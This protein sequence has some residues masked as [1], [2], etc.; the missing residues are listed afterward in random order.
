MKSKLFAI[1]TCALLLMIA[2]CEKPDPYV[3]PGSTEDPHWKVT[4]DTSSSA[5]MANMTAIVKVS[6]AKTSGTLAAFIGNDCC[7]IGDVVAD[8]LYYL[9]ITPATEA[10]GD[11]QLQ[12]YSPELKR[13][14]EATETFPFRND[15]HLGTV[16]QPYIPQWR[17]KT[18]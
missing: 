18:E 17:E 10:G 4:T 6:F 2:G 15:D 9:F 12:F 5:L 3:N 16:A 13:I 8:S 1:A 14:F 7:G 11:V